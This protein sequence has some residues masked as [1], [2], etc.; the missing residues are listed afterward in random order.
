VAVSAISGIVTILF[1]KDPWLLIPAAA[2][3]W[4]GT[5][6]A[7][8]KRSPRRPV[9]GGD[10]FYDADDNFFSVIKADGT[11]TAGKITHVR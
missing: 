9:D 5:Y 11:Y 2:G 4:V 3:A 10:P 1:V 8:W 7:K 6:A